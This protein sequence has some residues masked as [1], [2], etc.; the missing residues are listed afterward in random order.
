MEIE[1][2]REGLLGLVRHQVDGLFTLSA[3][4]A[5]T[6]RLR[7]DRALTRT[8]RCFAAID[9]PYYR[10]ASSADGVRF[11]P[12]QSS[13]YTIFLYF[14]S[15][16]VAEE[17]GRLADKLYYLNKTLNSVDL[18]HGVALPDIFV[19]DHPLGSVIGRGTFGD[20]FAFFQNCTVGNSAG[21]YPVLGRHVY[22][23]PGS[24]VIGRCRIGDRVIVGANAYVK[25]TDVPSQTLVFGASP[26]LILKPARAEHFARL[27]F[28]V[29]D[30]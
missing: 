15:R 5:E 21:E 18:Y 29:A 20:H 28:F 25:D 24:Q 13:Q 9:S 17:D 10:S 8:E 4:E 27:S 22:L 16:S 11:S 19:L 26:N 1:G 2:S 23:M 6:L 7:L 12:F 30:R 3:A 14:L